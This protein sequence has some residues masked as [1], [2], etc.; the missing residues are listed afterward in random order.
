MKPNQD[1]LGK[2]A[3]VTGG[4]GGLGKAISN[5]LAARGAHVTI[6]A[7]RPG[8]L[9]DAKNEIVGNCMDASRQEINAV[10]VNMADASAVSEAFR[11]Q[12]RIADF[13]YC[14]AGGNHAENGFF[15][16]LQATQLDSCMKNNY[17][18]T[19]YAAKAMLDIW[20]EN[21]KK[22]AGSDFSNNTTEH[23]T[24]K[25]VFVNSAAAFLGLPG[26]VAYTP[27]KS[28]V[29][30][31]ADT[32][33]FEVL[34]HNSSHTTYTIHIAF[35]ADFISPG[36]VLEQDTKPNL[37]KQIQGTNVATFAELE[38]KFPSSEEVARGVVARVD[39]G[40]FIICEDSLP[41][42][43]LF[44]NMIG[45]S[46]K[47]GLGIVDSLLSVV[48]GWF[49]VPVVRRRWERMCREDSSHSS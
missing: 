48:M 41:G 38:K 29:R 17:Y 43:L 23:T 4:S 10:A 32:L 18:S 7:R 47:R 39:K 12:P 44:T 25:I 35:P 45:L 37:T 42:Y 40:D 16:D 33:R 13:L 8:P 31:L 30:A 22:S 3:F 11:S 19:A 9:E 15:I 14:S 24:R 49:V 28:A 46:P 27:A 36:F 20:V 6:F 26:S 2:T 34:R 21:D 1:L 5:I